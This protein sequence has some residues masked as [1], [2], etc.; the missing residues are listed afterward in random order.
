MAE[1][2]DLKLPEPPLM[3]K[4]GEEE[5]ELKGLTWQDLQYFEKQ[6]KQEAL[7]ILDERKR[8]GKI[9][10]GEYENQS[11]S[12]LLSRMS[13]EELASHQWSTEGF[14]LALWLSIRHIRKDIKLSDIERKITK[15]NIT[16]VMRVGSL[17]LADAL[18]N[19]MERAKE[20]AGESS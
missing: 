6:A 3:M 16:E 19:P 12:I 5:Y 20:E 1:E 11:R 17:L 9:T 14:T 7:D 18:Q 2:L 4:L 8:D 13:F 15:G 10:S